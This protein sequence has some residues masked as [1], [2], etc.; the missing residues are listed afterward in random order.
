M[1]DRKGENNPNSK[2]TEEQVQKI[3]ELHEKYNYGC[4]KLGKMFGVGKSTIHRIL[5]GETWK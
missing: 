5:T 1:S 3:R 4:Y 2:L